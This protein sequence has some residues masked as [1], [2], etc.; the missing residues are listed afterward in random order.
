[1][2]IVEKK[3]GGSWATNYD[4]RIQKVTKQNLII[5][6]DRTGYIGE[7]VQTVRQYKSLSKNK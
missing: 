1:M 2:K 6:P 3:I 7:I 4:D 5:P